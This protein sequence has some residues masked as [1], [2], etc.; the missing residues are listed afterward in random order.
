M[1]A[2]QI[3]KGIQR[4]GDTERQREGET[5]R[6]RERR[7]EERRE[8]SKCVQKVIFHYCDLLKCVGVDSLHRKWLMS[9]QHKL[10]KIGSGFRH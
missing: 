1:R 3:E 2:R 4:D 9:S 6:G 5:E 10:A 7:G 8:I